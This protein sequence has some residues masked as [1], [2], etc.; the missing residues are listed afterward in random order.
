MLRRGTVAPDKPKQ[1]QDRSTSR[2]VI[3]FHAEFHDL[4]ERFAFLYPPPPT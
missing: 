1:Q 2:Y 4:V 3:A